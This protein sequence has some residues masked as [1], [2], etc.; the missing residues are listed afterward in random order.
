MVDPWPV[1]VTSIG[2]GKASF[3]SSR[4]VMTIIFLKSSWIE[5]MASTSFP[6]PL[7]SWV[8]KPSSMKRV[9]RGAPARLAGLT[10]FRVFAKC[11]ALGSREQRA[12][13]VSP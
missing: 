3:S 1:L 6:S 8:P 7:L 13:P 11:E 9:G 10:V 2:T 12:K 4:W 5:C